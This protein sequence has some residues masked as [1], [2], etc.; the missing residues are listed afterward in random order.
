M[1]SAHAY[2][3]RDRGHAK[4]TRRNAISS[5]ANSK[6]DVPR[7]GKCGNKAK[8]ECLRFGLPLFE[9][10][11]GRLVSSLAVWEITTCLPYD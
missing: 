7:N 10:Q 5:S 9:L 4:V 1:Y 3:L 6:L 2:V 11:V 8:Q